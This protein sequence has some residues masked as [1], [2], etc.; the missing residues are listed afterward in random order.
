MGEY[1]RQFLLQL[2]H[3]YNYDD[4]LRIAEQQ[5]GLMEQGL[6]NCSGGF[7]FYDTD[8]T[9][10]RI[11]C[12]YKYG[13]CH[14]WI[15]EQQQQQSFD[16]YLLTD[17]DLPWEQDPLRE[18]PDARQ[19]LFELYREALLRQGWPFEIVSGTGQARLDHAIRII[20]TRY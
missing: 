16:L 5:S 1:A 19:E 10:L 8:F 2:G 3:P 18:H 11:W 7:I 12:E 4:I 17:T 6:R 9:V 14:P 13:K 20:E 15:V